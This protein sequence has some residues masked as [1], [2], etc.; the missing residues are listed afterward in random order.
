MLK[1]RKFKEEKHSITG[2]EEKKAYRQSVLDG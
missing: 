1:K 2:G